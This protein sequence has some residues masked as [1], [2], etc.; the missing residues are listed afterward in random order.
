MDYELSHPLALRG[1]Y[2][3]RGDKAEFLVKSCFQVYV[4][5]VVRVRQHVANR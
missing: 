4:H 2:I 3:Q 5:F 1:K